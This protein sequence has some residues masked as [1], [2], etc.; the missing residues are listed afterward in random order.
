MIPSG[1]LPRATTRQQI[2]SKNRDEG[3]TGSH[4]QPDANPPQQPCPNRSAAQQGNQPLQGPRQQQDSRNDHRH[5]ETEQQQQ[6]RESPGD[7]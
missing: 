7:R 6:N 4:H 3:G 1:R 2:Q 5:Q